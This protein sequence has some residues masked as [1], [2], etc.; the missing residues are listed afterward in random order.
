M[1]RSCDQC[2]HDTPTR[3]GEGRFSV[4]DRDGNAEVL[5]GPRIASDTDRCPG[6]LPYP[7]DDQKVQSIHATSGGLPGL[8]KRR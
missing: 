1:S 2:G 8:G 7:V 4:H 6:S 5:L 3:G